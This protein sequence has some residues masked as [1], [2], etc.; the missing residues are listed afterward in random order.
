MSKMDV[1]VPVKLTLDSKFKFRCHKAIKCFTKC[2]SNIDILLTP[3]DMLRL[4]NRLR[5]SSGEFL[6]KYTYVKID[7]KSSLPHV[8]LRMTD[9]KERTCPFVNS[10]GCT[11]YTDR[12]ANCRYYPIGQ[13]TLRKAGEKGPEEEEF[14]FFINETHCLGYE[15]DKKW[16]IKSWRIDQE[17]NVYDEMNRDW[18][19]MQ[20]RKN[21]QAQDELDEK[22]QAQVYMACYDVDGFR[23]F[24]FESRFLD[25]FD[26]DNK[27][28][29]KIKTDESELMKFGFNYVKYI[30]MVE[31]TLKFKTGALEAREKNNHS[32]L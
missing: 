31:Q 12:P 16:T 4:K 24:I 20:L 1:V 3:Y 14:Y 29:E 10:E 27:I 22:K 6:S 9:D 7:E 32:K 23:R 11:I 17:V 30:L 18:K 26:I 13:G 21:T 2:C 28:I 19:A 8:I 25:I 15:D 5:L